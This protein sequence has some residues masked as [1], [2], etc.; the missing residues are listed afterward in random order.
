MS[1]A[2]FAKECPGLSGSITRLY[3]QEATTQIAQD[4]CVAADLG[5]NVELG[6]TREEGVSFNPRI[7]RIVSLVIQDCDS[8]NPAMVRV[9]VYSSVSGDLMAPVP[10]DIASDVMALKVVSPQSPSWLKGLSLALTL[11]RVRHLHMIEAPLDEK[12]TYLQEVGCSALVVPG[13]G[14]PE[15]LRVKVLHAVDLQSRRLS[16]E[17]E[18]G[19]Q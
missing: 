4:Y 18:R 5:G 16:E 1:L 9:A 3:G 7:A 14:A 2:R 12:A 17:R 15:R 6:L 10:S 19:R 13:S 11:D 8:V